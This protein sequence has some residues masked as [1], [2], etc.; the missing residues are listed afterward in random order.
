MNSQLL[1]ILHRTL[2]GAL[3]ILLLPLCFNEALG[4]VEK[5]A[6]LLMEIPCGRLTLAQ[7]Q[8]TALSA[9]PQV[10]EMLARIKEAD[11]RCRQA[12]AALW[13]TVSVH[14]GHDW[15]DLSMRPDWQPQVRVEESFTHFNA[16]IQANWLLFDGFST[17][18][19]ILAA[20][21]DK[22]AGKSIAD[23]ARRLVVQAVATAFY[24]AQ[25]AA[26]G[27]QI[28]RQNSLFN[29]RLEQDAEK[30]CRAGVVPRAD[31]LNFSVKSLQAENNFLKA[32][33]Y[34]A[35]ACAMLARLMVWPDPTLSRD[36]VPVA[37][38]PVETL[39]E[40]PQFDRELAY[41][42]DRRPDLKSL[43]A[44]E[45]ALL[46]TRISDKGRYFPKL[47]LKAGY[48]YDEYRNYGTINQTEHGSAIGLCFDW[49]L[50]SGGLRRAKISETQAQ[51]IR[52]NHEKEQKIL[53]IRAALEQAL[54]R[55]DA[56]RAVYQREQ[57]TL[58]L[59]RQIRDHVEKS[60]RAGATTLTRLNEAQTDLVTLSAAAATSRIN[61]LQ[62][63]EALRA[64]SGR[65]L[66]DR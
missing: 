10:K 50:F 30:R 14:A 52:L 16:G 65:N 64:E 36:M 41:A 53:E 56:A 8:K 45:E 5:P 27:M 22:Q 19:S 26:Q 25:L 49:D 9:S 48:D 47:Y 12:R 33:Q 13:P 20:E 44:R 21:A 3:L 35:V 2:G 15:Q 54:V 42:M 66:E 58:T 7:A 59:V 6:P 46:H 43:A 57:Y 61:Y 51:L 62:Q 34:H 55:A 18:A 23:D 28:A 17:R 37:G 38:S 60:Y 4:E 32:G 39:E 29:R 40:L 11:A 63:L 1:K 31:Y 24:Q